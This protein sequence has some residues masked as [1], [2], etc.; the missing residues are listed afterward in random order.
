MMTSSRRAIASSHNSKSLQSCGSEDRHRS[1]KEN[2]RVPG[3]NPGPQV[4]GMAGGLDKHGP[5]SG[6]TFLVSLLLHL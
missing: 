5:G 1:E 2:Q 6:L 3:R 4:Q